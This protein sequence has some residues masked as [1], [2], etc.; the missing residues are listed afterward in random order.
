MATASVPCHACFLHFHVDAIALSCFAQLCSHLRFLDRDH[1][2][3]HH[4]HNRR[5][6]LSSTWILL[7]GRIQYLRFDNTSQH[8]TRF[9]CFIE[10]ATDDFVETFRVIL[11]FTLY[12]HKVDLHEFSLLESRERDY[13]KSYSLCSKKSEALAKNVKS[14]WHFQF[15]D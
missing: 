8:G 11:A 6:T 10:T 3:T 13:L 5:F 12:L 1:T 2:R 7:L 15:F 4:H 9:L 14:A